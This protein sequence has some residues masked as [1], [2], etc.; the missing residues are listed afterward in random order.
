MDVC[1]AAP[2]PVWIDEVE[3][4]KRTTEQKLQGIR[5]PDHRRPP[6]LRFEGSSLHDITINLSGCCQKLMT[7]ANLAIIQPR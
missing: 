6:R 2:P 7:M 3:Q 1:L 5:C 4:F